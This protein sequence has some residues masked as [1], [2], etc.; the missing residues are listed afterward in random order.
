MVLLGE[1]GIGKS[2][3]FKA[4]FESIEKAISTINDITLWFDLR[5]Y[6][7]DDRLERTVFKHEVVEKWR[8]GQHTLH[9]FFDSLDEA[10]LR[11]DNVSRVLLSELECCAAG[12]PC[13]RK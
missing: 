3:S 8:N 1:P 9:L 5:D 7:S 4:E 12:I 6:S 11:L 13:R 2:A 10:L